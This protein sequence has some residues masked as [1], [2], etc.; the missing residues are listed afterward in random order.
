MYPVHGD[1]GGRVVTQA[2]LAPIPLDQQDRRRR[3]R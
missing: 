1:E 3:V 2:A